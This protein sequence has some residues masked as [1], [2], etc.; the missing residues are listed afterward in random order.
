[1]AVSQYLNETGE[2]R[3]KV[4]VNTRSKTTPA[5]RA[6][7][8]ASG[9]KTEKEAGRE[10]TKLVREC[11]RE[12]LEKESQGSTWGAVVAAFE[13][14]LLTS[15]SGDAL[16]ATTRQDYVAAVRKHTSEL[17]KRS[18]ASITT[19]DLRELFVN[20]RAQGLSW[21]HLNK[22]RAAIHRMYVFAMES[23]LIPDLDRS[24]TTNLHLKKDEEKRPEI[25]TIT[26][27]RRL[28]TSAR[29]MEH[30]WYPIWALAL[31]TGMRSG[32]LYALTW[33]DV[34]LENSSVSVNKS[35]NCRMKCIK[36]TKAG[37]WRTVPI[38]SELKALLLDLKRDAEGRTT[39]LPR[40]NKW[41][42]GLQAKEL[43]Q[44]CIGIGLPS[45]RFHALRAC[46]ATQLI[47][48]GVPPIQ[49]QKI[50]GWRDLKTMQGYIR[51]AGIETEGAT[52]GLK[53]LPEMDLVEKAADLFTKAPTA[54]VA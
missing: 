26:E 11:E 50:C 45:I 36:S 6:Q 37:Y 44:F 32:E 12:I 23:R 42:K 27:L 5:L 30:P 54:K 16:Q 2:T 14:H 22:V 52:E 53:V 46:F 49:I 4:Y 9:F 43:R 39:V 48:N 40:M 47:R 28:L 20:L 18:A 38:S 7:R 41:T 25:L 19:A 1:M 13:K 10:E 17:W 15:S 29:E 35:Y 3:F 24:P 31:L 21:G 34:S 8:R 51:L 33:S